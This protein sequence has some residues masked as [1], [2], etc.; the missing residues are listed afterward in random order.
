MCRKITDRGVASIA[1]GIT[2]LRSINLYDCLLL[3]D[4][5]IIALAKNCAYLE[6]FGAFGVPNITVRAV[7]FLIQKCRFLNKIDIGGCLLIPSSLVE[8]LAKQHPRITF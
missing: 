2:G 5:T 7:Q 4:Q 1:E 6:Y 3:T 8:V